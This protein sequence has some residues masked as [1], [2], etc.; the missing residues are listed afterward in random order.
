MI[1]LNSKTRL[2]FAANAL[3]KNKNPLKEAGFTLIE[4]LMA[5]AVVSILVV[6]IAPMVA[7]STSAR[8][9]ARRV[10]QATQA[11]KSYIEAVRGKVYDTAKF[12]ASLLSG[13]NTQGQYIFDVAAPTTATFAVPSGCTLNIADATQNNI[14]GGRVPGVCVDANGDG[15]RVDDPQDLV[16]QPMRSGGTDAE[17]LADVGFWLAIRVYR[18]DAFAT[19]AP[20]LFKGS[21]SECA[22]SQFVFVS[23]SS[24]RCPL[25]TM[26]SQIILNL[27]LN[28]NQTGTGTKDAN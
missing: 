21:E 7:L 4:S 20:A 1:N 22:N 13:V 12:P 8:V 6:S 23:G 14:N 5:V 25:V 15:F 17:K 11:G 27:N 26:R 10:D 9:N 3:K 18:A 24:T 28:A 2:I 19:G 16:I